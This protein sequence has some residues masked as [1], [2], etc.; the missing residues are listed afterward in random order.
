MTTQIDWHYRQRMEVFT[1]YLTNP[2][3]SYK[4][5]SIS[6]FVNLAPQ[7][8][9]TLVSMVLFDALGHDCD[10]RYLEPDI[11]ASLGT[12]RLA[13]NGQFGVFCYYS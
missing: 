9:T 12:P 4:H 10:P 6:F 11:L 8:F 7:M 1:N 5:A 3:Y 13:Q 2:Q